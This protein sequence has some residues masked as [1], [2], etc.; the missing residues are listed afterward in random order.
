MAGVAKYDTR[1]QQVLARHEYVGG[2]VSGELLF[3]PRGGV[4]AI[5]D[6]AAE[7]NGYLVTFVYYEKTDSRWVYIYHIGCT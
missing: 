4:E 6:E 1:S 3:A 7:D 5:G 2:G